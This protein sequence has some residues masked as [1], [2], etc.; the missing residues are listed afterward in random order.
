MLHGVNPVQ[1]AL[2]SLHCENWKGL[3]LLFV[4]RQKAASSTVPLC[5]H[6]PCSLT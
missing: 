6:G 3:D 2:P 1:Q 5:L 4:Q